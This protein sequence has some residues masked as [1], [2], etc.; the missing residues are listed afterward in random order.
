[1]VRTI[2]KKLFKKD[3]KGN[4]LYSVW[5]GSNKKYIVNNGEKRKQLEKLEE[6]RYLILSYKPPII[7]P[8]IVF[9]MLISTGLVFIGKV[10]IEIEHMMIQITFFIYLTIVILYISKIYAILLGSKKQSSERVS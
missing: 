5:K 7:I 10:H 8:I 6:Y 1:M 9:S 4:Y 3:D 2:S